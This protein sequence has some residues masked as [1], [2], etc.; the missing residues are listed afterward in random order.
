MIW[1]EWKINFFVFL[2]YGRLKFLVSFEEKKSSQISAIVLRPFFSQLTVYRPSSFRSVHIYIKNAHCTKSHEISIF[3]VVVDCVYNFQ[4]CHRPEI[5]KKLLS[6]ENGQV[7][8][9]VLKQMKNKF[10]VFEIW[11]IFNWNS[12]EKIM[13]RGS[14][15]LNL[16]FLWKLRTPHAPPG[17]RL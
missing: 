4:V 14:A 2:R 6:Y 1:N 16:P 7:Y 17:L 5:T 9:N 3:W 11:S 8:R 15:A 10:L 12:K 13:L